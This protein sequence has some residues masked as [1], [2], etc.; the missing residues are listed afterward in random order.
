MSQKVIN[1]IAVVITAVWAMS[2][3]ADALMT[4]YSPAPEVHGI[5]MIV[6][7]AAFGRNIIKRNGGNGNGK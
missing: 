1:G 4:T 7:G 3:I 2:S 5:M 6:A